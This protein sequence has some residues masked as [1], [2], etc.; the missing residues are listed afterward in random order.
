MAGSYSDAAIVSSGIEARS[1][2]N[3]RTAT[4]D[5]YLNLT[6]EEINANPVYEG[7]EHGD[8][9]VPYFDSRAG[10]QI[11]PFLKQY[12]TYYVDGTASEPKKFNDAIGEENGV[13]TN[14]LSSIEPLYKT[15]PNAAKDQ[16]FK[17]PGADYISSLG[18]LSIAYLTRFQLNGGQRLLDLHIGSDVPGYKNNALDPAQFNL[19]TE[20]NDSMKK[21][22]LRSVNLTNISS[23]ATGINLSG[24]AKLE[25]FRGLDTPLTEVVFA[26][27]AP[28]HTIHLP[29]TIT[30]F[31][32]TEA[33]D[34]TDLITSRPSVGT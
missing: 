18:D 6:Q 29:N 14:V 34:L 20:V 25:E 13:W 26:A 5:K 3:N 22:L 19:H 10:F 24:S 1:A 8:Y 33:S 17:I 2:A 23:L 12:V 28:L 27:G 9:P 32:I 30:S 16:I 11:R 7:F 31:A 4:S 15:A 21:P